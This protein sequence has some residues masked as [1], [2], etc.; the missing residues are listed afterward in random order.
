MARKCIPCE[1]GIPPL[2]EK[3][4][5][6]ELAKL[7]GWVQRGKQIEKDFSFQTYL[8]GL[9][10]VNSVGNLAEEEGHHPEM[11]L[12]YKRLRITLT[13]FAIGGLSENDFILASK[14]DE[15]ASGN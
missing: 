1:G 4:I 12:G 7:N 9:N 8:D 10:F 3:Q 2:D 15:L 13:T 11:S 6:D 14:I 5:H